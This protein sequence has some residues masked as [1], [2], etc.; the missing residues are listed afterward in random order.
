[1]STRSCPAGPDGVRVM[2]VLNERTPRTAVDVYRA[3]E[4]LK[5][6]G[7]LDASVV[8][9]YLSRLDELRDRTLVVEDLIRSVTEFRPSILLWVHAHDLGISAKVSDMLRRA[10]GGCAIGFWEA[11]WYD[12]FQKPFPRQTLGLLK[13]SDTVFVC[14]EGAFSGW[15]KRSGCRDVRYVP[16]TGDGR[17]VEH[18]VPRVFDFDVVMIGSKV[19]S[20]V[21]FRTMGGAVER[22][23]LVEAFTRQYGA[24]FAVF[25]HGWAGPSAQGPVPFEQQADIC[26]R[27]AC[28]LGNNHLYAR[29]YF[30]NR[31]PIAMQA[32]RP[33]VHARVEG[34]EE[35]F[36]RDSGVRWFTTIEEALE[37]AQGVVSNPS[38]TAADAEE[39]R[40]LA[41]SRFTTF[42]ALSYMIRVLS[43][44][45]SAQTS[46]EGIV[47]NP[48]IDR[49]R[50]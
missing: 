22:S 42:H 25:G 27:A 29:Y 50:L 4:R 30:S 38:C 49:E 46:A 16:S 5:A 2:V 36:G 13:S 45:R 19:R 15:L 6:E 35:V 32:G 26:G 28:V 3:L 21:P 23:K 31:L 44:K 24:R 39:A 7:G 1:M 10:S 14:G 20:R 11:D 17:F 37:K 9:P 12:W 40:V 41:E 18:L 33:V 47:A 34:Y 48:W 43:S 8:Y